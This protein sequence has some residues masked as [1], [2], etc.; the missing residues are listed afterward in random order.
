MSSRRLALVVLSI[1]LLIA[2]LLGVCFY[3]QPTSF[4]IARTRTFS[5]PPSVVRAQ[6]SNIRAVAA[7]FPS[8]RPA[9]SAARPAAHTPEQELQRS[10][11][12]TES[13]VGAW[14]ES[15]DGSGFSRTSIVSITDARVELQT[16]TGGAF[17]SGSTRT[18]FEL[19]QVPGDPGKTTVTWAFEGGLSGMRRALWPVV[20][21]DKRLGPELDTGLAKLEAELGQAPAK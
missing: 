16:E 14:V 2:L 17:G 11:S 15:R 18:L 12:P 21:L 8:M 7:A 6:L 20:S 5:A 19:S 10:F 3:S 9:Q 4:R 1:P 13:G